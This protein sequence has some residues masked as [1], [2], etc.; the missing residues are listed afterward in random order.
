MSTGKYFTVDCGSHATSTTKVVAYI[1][2]ALAKRFF[3]SKRLRFQFAAPAASVI[4]WNETTR[5][6]TTAPLRPPGTNDSDTC[7]PCDRAGKPLSPQPN[8]K[9]FP[10]ER[11]KSQ[12]EGL[13][14]S[15]C[16]WSSVDVQFTVSA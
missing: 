14:R 4:L 6:L 8:G 10:T 1:D 7:R 15:G 16:S 5:M 11:T 3:F 9:H 12:A 13:P 2:A